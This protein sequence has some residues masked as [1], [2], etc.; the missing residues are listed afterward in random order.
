MNAAAA[1][2]IYRIV[3]SGST[4]LVGMRRRD[5]L[6]LLT[7]A[8]LYSQSNQ[9]PQ[10]NWGTQIGDVAPGRALIWSRSDRPARMIV[11]WST[12][13]SFRDPK[14][15]LGSHAIEA[16]DLTA[17]VDLRELPADQRIFYRVL[18]QSLADGKTLGEPATG[19]FRTAPARPRDIRFVWSGDTAGQGFGINPD[20]GGMK[21][22]ERMRVREPDFFLH[23]GDTIY[24][25]G[26]IP[27][28]VKLRD[29]SIWKNITTEAKSKPAETLDD[30]RGAYLYN[31]LDENV[32]R[33]NA[34]VPQIWQWDDHEVLNNWSPS[35]DLRS[36]AL[37]KEKSVFLL[38]ARA[39]RA[40]LEYAP[41]R[42]SAEETERIYRY[43]PYGPL[44]DVFVI[45]MRTY[46][47]PN[48]YNRQE[49]PIQDTTYL[50]KPQ[51][52]WLKRGLAQSR[53]VWKVIAADMPIGVVVPDGKDAEGRQVW[54]NSAN[55][56][57]PALGRELEI[58]DLL[59]SFKRDSVKNVVWLTADTHYTAAHYFDPSKAQFQDFDPFWEFIS[60]P[61]NAGSFGPGTP[62]NTFGPEV[63]FFKAPPKG[64]SGLAPSAGLQFFG[65]VNIDTRTRSFTVTLRDVGGAELFV[66][67]IDPV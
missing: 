46:R 23:S 39:T 60:G 40:F 1:V 28:E 55:G 32:R 61:L 45:D 56:N 9:R 36:N 41:M 16:T 20:W 47:G 11:E 12:T 58:A 7:A 13:E 43:I 31:L 34:W 59:R 24:A 3:T 27:A 52:D 65:E 53:A 4:T 64:Q 2:I 22:Y 18:F 57:G 25:D 62:D 21:T 49:I 67:R 38:A 17:R 19:H 37:Y 66:Q 42:Y 6:S 54:E 26:P 14:R 51:L 48:T 15:I 30:F 35:K 63:K 33:F 10:A 50:G 29:G 8:P 44:L 5:L